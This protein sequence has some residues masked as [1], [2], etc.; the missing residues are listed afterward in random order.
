MQ[1]SDNISFLN[2]TNGC[3]YQTINYDMDISAII[4]FIL[5]FVGISLLIIWLRQKYNTASI[6]KT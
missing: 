1:V 4:I 3:F 6:A 5:T 2:L